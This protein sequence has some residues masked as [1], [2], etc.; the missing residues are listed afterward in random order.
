MEINHQIMFP[1]LMAG[2]KI[3]Y[4]HGFCSSAQSGTVTRLRSMLPDAEVVAYDL[5]IHPEEA[6][7]LL[8]HKCEVDKP[9]LIIGTSMGGM[10]TEMLYGFDR[11]L[12]NP[13]FEM[14]STMKEH[15]MMGKQTFFNPRQDGVQEFIVTKELVKEYREM[16]E[17][18]FKALPSPSPQPSRVEAAP[19]QLP[20]GGETLDSNERS[21]VTTNSSPRGGRE[22][23]SG[24][25][26]GL[27]GMEDPLVH[28][29]DLFHEHY[30]NAVRFH[31]EHQ[32]IDKTVIHALIPV[33]RWIDDKQ[34]GRE[35]EIIY[36]SIETLRD[37]YGKPRSS[38]A[39]ALSFLT[40]FY[41]VQFVCPSPTN[42]PEQVAEDIRWMEDQIGVV[43]YNHINLTNR[44][45]LLYGDYFI[46]M[47]EIDGCLGTMIEF[48]SDQFKTWEEIIVYF[49]RLRS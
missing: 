42:H 23:A 49:E 22:G 4:V 6:M 13:A 9:D 21:N 7:E 30:P 45:S 28:T 41:D 20:R 14:G 27:F 12:V 35:R 48:G 37:Q 46:S 18:C 19:L 17:K 3:M 47:N 31:G 16:T 39:K 29:F 38:V 44:P 8:R 2:K 25:V 1:G 11:I 32:L 36:V 26:Y 15:S 43:A 33:I 40:E 10:Y 5:P 34:E 24:A